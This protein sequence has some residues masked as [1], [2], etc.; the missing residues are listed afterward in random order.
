MNRRVVIALLLVTSPAAAQVGTRAEVPVPLPERPFVLLDAPRRFLPSEPAQVR[1]QVRGGGEVDVA[2]FAVHEPDAILGQAGARQGLSVAATNLGEEAEALLASPASPSGR[3]LSI[4]SRRHVVMPT[5]DALERVSNETV[6][7]DSNEDVQDGVATYWVRDGDWAVDRVSF[8]R[9]RP[10]LYLVQVRAAAWVASALLSVGE[11]VL[12]ARRG[13]RADL[14]RVTD[15]DGAPVA[16]LAVQ[17][18]AGARALASATTGPDGVARFAASDEETVRFR[19]ARGD[20]LAWADAAHARLAPCDPRV[21]VATGRPLFRL[22]EQMHLRGHVRGCPGGAPG[23]LAGARVTVTAG[24]EPIEVVTDANGDFVA[25]VQASGTVTATLGGRAHVREVRIDHR[26]LPR[27]DLIVEAARPWAAA[28]EVVRVRVADADGGWPT[29]R[30]VVLDT[31]FGR[32]VAPIGPRRPAF[33]ELRVPSAVSALDRVALHASVASGDTVV[34]ASTELLVGRSRTLLELDAEVERGAPGELVALEARLTDLGGAPLD[35]PVRLTVRGSDGNRALG[36]AR[37]RMDAR[38]AGGRVAVRL[39]LAG[40]GPWMIEG[41]HEHASASL[42]IWER[43]RPPVLARR[44]EL[45]VSPAARASRPGEALAVDVR[46]PAGSGR[47]WLTLEQGGVLEHA[48]IDAAG[49]V[50]RVSLTVPETARGL[51][52]VVI[53]HVA[54]GIVA[55]ASATV[56]VETSAPMSLSVASDRAVYSRGET[57][58]VVLEARTLRDGRP[59]D[60]VVSLWLADAGYWGLGED[61]YPL[62]DEYLRLPGR[63]ASGADSTVPI[64]FGAEEGRRLETELLVD[65]RALDRATHRHGWGHGGAVVDVRARGPIAAIARALA[66]AAGLARGA[67]DCD[68]DEGTAPHTV[69]ARNLPWDLVALR[70]AEATDTTVSVDGRTLRFDCAAIGSFGAGGSGRGG[71]GMGLGSIGAVGHAGPAREARLE[72][73]LHFVGLAPLGPD[74]RLEL[75]VPLPDHPGRW[76]VEAIAIASDGA[77]ARAHRV[78][79]TRQA[80]EG[81]LEVPAT[82]RPGDRAV[83]TVHVRA[84]RGVARAEIAL[85]PSEGLRVLEAPAAAIALEGGRG[86]AAFVIEA[87]APGAARLRLDVRAGGAPSAP[88]AAIT[89]AASTSIDVRPPWT[90]HSLYYGVAIGPGATDVEVPLPALASRATFDVALDPSPRAEVERLLELVRRPRW[91]F[92]PLRAD[93]L[94]SLAA[95]RRVARASADPSLSRELDQAVEGEL[96]ALRQYVTSSGELGWRDHAD[97]ALTLAVLEHAGADAAE[98]APARARLRAR[99]AR[100]ELGP[101]AH[102]R[103]ARL[104]DAPDATDDPEPGLERA[105]AASAGD[106]EAI[107]QVVLAAHHFGRH[108]LRRRAADVLLRAIDARLAQATPLAVC[109]GAV[110][111]LCYGRQSDRGVLARAALALAR[112]PDPRAAEVAAR[113]GAWIARQPAR[114][115]PLIWGTDEADVLELFATL[116]RG[117]DSVE[118]LLDDRPVPIRGGVVAVPE[119]A[120]RLVLR[121]AARADRLRRVVVAGA[122]D[123]ADPSASL[124]EVRVSRE[125]EREDGAWRARVRFELAREAASATLTLPLP[126]GLTLDPRG[127][128]RALAAS[129]SFVD[130]AVVLRL[131]ATR[132]GRHELVL[133]LLAAGTGTYAAGPARLV[134]DDA[135]FGL[136]PAAIVDV[137]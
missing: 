101:E 4:A 8:G 130:G 42:V 60:A 58:R 135:R 126:A 70:V 128:D 15:A 79:H 97:P 12:V 133:P 26:V 49:R 74:G 5:A 65:G 59:R 96:A 22:V 24:G 90:R 14:A 27:R 37:H 121:F 35:G 119:G 45:A 38:A 1:L 55:T 86:S 10:G 85:S 36:P 116:P 2:L 88:G 80:I 66:R 134:L 57:A 105:L 28:G 99:Y 73:T 52:S 19:V 44:G 77:G 87:S 75:D 68:G 114:P 16:G 120:H 113:V 54:R 93:R 23:P 129:I 125:L 63:P 78:V 95:L 56:E 41:E 106:P 6:V 50:T 132:A 136:T 20:D 103:A 127:L 25:Q 21:Y 13:D 131:G 11:L 9:L 67:S 46:L 111:F 3:R 107:A 72:G 61:T 92:A 84:G 104:L 112:T 76:R 32:L 18:F 7:Y 17:T 115:D 108:A 48:P 82:L 51:A 124:G 123:V 43:A 34:M 40:A 137:R 39:P 94:A 69:V 64:G 62:P 109:R 83:G 47:A 33:F 89:D 30:D 122:A 53:T 71:G 117:A 31:P 29:A 98:W 91:S 118:A 102:A 81:W 100:G 110:W